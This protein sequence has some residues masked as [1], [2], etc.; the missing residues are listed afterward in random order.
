MIK[1][2]SDRVWQADEAD[3]RKLCEGHSER[4]LTEGFKAVLCPA[5]NVRIPYHPRLA[6]MILPVWDE[7]DAPSEMFDCA[8]YFH[9]AF[10]PTLVHCHGG[11][12]RSS[13]FAAALLVADGMFV[14]KALECVNATPNPELLRSLRRWVQSR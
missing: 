11:L 8:A 4:W 1:R 10:G 9:K 12:N 14:E 2:L 13:A 6:A 3:A 5:F 7:T